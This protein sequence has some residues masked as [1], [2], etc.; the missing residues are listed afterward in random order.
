MDN[1]SDRAL[2]TLY[3]TS[4]ALHD[5]TAGTG[6]A[7]FNV[8]CLVKIRQTR[9]NML[10]NI[11]ISANTTEKLY[12]NVPKQLNVIFQYRKKRFQV[13][14]DYDLLRCDLYLV[15]WYQ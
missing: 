3:V 5:F 9:H 12:I 7:L 6:A 1:W 10:Y 14:T 2:S 11:F 4:L 15:N 8:M 13:L